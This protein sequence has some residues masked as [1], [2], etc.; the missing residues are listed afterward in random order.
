[1]LLLA[2]CIFAGGAAPTAAQTPAAETLPQLA[3]DIE[4]FP[5]LGHTRSVNSVKFSPDGRWVLSGSDDGTVKLWDVV[6]G[7]EVR[8][9]AGHTDRISS[10]AFS[11][12]GRQVLSGSN[13]ETVKLWDMV[14]GREVRTFT[15]HTDPVCS[16]A[17]SPDG[18]QV[19]SGSWGPDNNFKL[20][21]VVTGKE[22]RTFAGHTND[23]SSVAFSPDG[24]HVLSGA[25][26]DTVKLWDVVTGKEVRTF[27]VRSY[28]NSVAFSPDGKQV[29]SGNYDGIKLWDT[30]T[31]KEMRPLGHTGVVNSVVFSPDGKQILSG[32]EDGTIALWDVVIGKEVRTFTGHTGSVYS[33]AFSPDGRQVLSGSWDSTVKLWD[34]ATGREIRTF[35]GHTSLVLSAAFSPDGKQVLSGSSDNTVKLWDAAIGGKIRTLNGHTGVVNSVVFSPDGGQVLSGSGRSYLENADQDYTVKLWDAATG[36]E[37]RTFGHTYP[38]RSVAFSPDGKQVLSGSEDPVLWDVAT[39]REIK[40]LAKENNGDFHILHSVAFS[41]DGRQVLS[42]FGDHGGSEGIIKLWDAATGREIRTMVHSDWVNSI[43]F[44]PNGKQILSGSGRNDYIVSYTK[45]YTIKLWDAA[46]GREIRTFAGHKNSVNSVA[47]SPDGRQILSGSLDN[48][49]KLWDATTGREIK[50]FLGHTNRVTSV[51]FSS[52]GKRILSGSGDG[53]TRIWDTATGKEIAAFISFSG[54]DS[55]LNGGTRG[56][57]AEVETAATSI[58]GEWVVITPD[59]YYAASPRGDRY[60]NVRIGNTVTG[61]DSFRSVFYNPDVVRARLAGEP[62]PVSKATVT[63]Q[64]AAQFLPP[65]VDLQTETRTASSSTANISVSIT[66]K[67][68]PV[69]NIIVMVNGRRLGADELAAVS[70]ATGLQPN[71]ASLTVMGNQKTLNLKLPVNLD[72]GDN[73]IEVVAFNGYSE[74][75]RYIDVVYNAPTGAKPALPDLW[76]LAIGVNKYDNAGAGLANMKDL[77]YCVADAR[78]VIDSLKTQE[79]VRYGKVR[80]L[81]VADDAEVKPTAANI[82]QSFTF[83][84]DAKPRDVVL[85]F[86]AGH[87]VSAQ[88]GKF[89]FLSR[90]AVVSA[91]KTVDSSRAISGDEIVSVLDAPGNRLVFIDACQAGGVDN[92]RMVRSLMDTNA[93]VF[94]A[95]RGNE[96]SYE[97]AELGHGYFTNSIMDALKGA[98]TAQA[99]GNVSVISMSG[100]VKDDVLRRVRQKFGRDQNPSAYSLGFYDFPLSVIK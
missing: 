16:V 69:K 93:F 36:R 37:I 94:A 42:G 55:Q 87:G 72:P 34:A 19:L 41:P 25:N 54:S 68:L 45:D 81:L 96:F 58:D 74:N 65:E 38:V 26:D 18:K 30:A 49:V 89:Y 51:M 33:V 98:T 12:D 11:P 97:D 1:M 2:V 88:E 64:Q 90:D 5:Q 76:I 67:N 29:L 73:R 23:V 24:R 71:K 31:G 15:G 92:D 27:M 60:L 47:F 57:N 100:Y 21:D 14:T 75:R 83:L 9:F 3:A 13:D 78:G 63:I 48:T 84:D 8:T 20:W 91:T 66:D 62:D 4:V 32:Y 17:F 86:L 40:I 95:C 85:L 59:G 28:G 44:S 52:D 10:V 79:G 50:T 61:I 80:S 53:T 39:G 70:G 99:A 82:R 46:T 22:V 6:T 43:T 35:A 77:N 56:I 7:K